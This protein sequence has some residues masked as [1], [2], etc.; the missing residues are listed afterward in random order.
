MPKR[1][2]FPV[3]LLIILVISVSACNS[4]NT[5]SA[6]FGLNQEIVDPRFRE[7]YEWMGGEQVLGPPISPKFSHEGTEYQ[8]TSTILMVFSAQ[9]A[10]NQRLQFAPLGVDFGVAEPPMNPDAPNGHNIYS[11]FLAKYNQMGGA[12]YVGLPITEVRYNPE[13]KRVEQYFENAGFYHLESDTSGEVFLIHYGSWKCAE[14]CGFNSPEISKVGTLSTGDTP[15][16]TAVSRLDPG[17]TGYPLTEPYVAFDGMLEQIFE[18]VVVVADPNNPGGI[19]LRPMLGMLGVSV[20][21]NGFSVPQYFQDYLSRN[22][23]MDL[24]GPSISEYAE[25]SSDVHRQCYTNLCLDYHTKAPADLKVRPA[26][27]GYS[28]KNMFYQRASGESPQNEI[29]MRVWEAHPLLAQGQSQVIGTKISA[30]NTPLKN[31]EPVLTLFVP[32]VGE[33]PYKFPPTNEDGITNVKINPLDIP[34]GTR[35]EYQV[36]VMN[37]DERFCSVDDFLLWE[38]VD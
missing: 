31:F 17:F 2:F 34:N 36:C 16:A 7:F 10:S 23:G 26:P 8:Y 35:V 18:N 28:Y 24:S 6:T 15:F 13:K 22:T 30:S 3:I 33:I 14:A 32:G 27:L 19:R 29:S 37:M 38:P 25:L 21:N 20:V 5:S 11:G 1:Y 12:R 4:G 9:A